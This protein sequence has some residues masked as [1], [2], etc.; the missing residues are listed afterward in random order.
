[1]T[2]VKNTA[3]NGD[4]EGS[5]QLANKEIVS[6]PLIEREATFAEMFTKPR[7]FNA[8]ALYVNGI[9]LTPMTIPIDSTSTLK[10]MMLNETK[11][12]IPQFISK[13]LFE[14][15]KQSVEDQTLHDCFSFMTA[16]LKERDIRRSF[17]Y[18][19]HV[20]LSGTTSG[21]FTIP[22]GA[23]AWMPIQFVNIYGA[24]LHWGL[25]TGDGRILHKYGVNAVYLLTDASQLAAVYGAAMAFCGSYQ[26]FCNKCLKST[27]T[28]LCKCMIAQYCSTK[29]QKD[30]W[31]FHKTRCLTD[32][33]RIQIMTKERETSILHLASL[34]KEKQ[35]IEANA[36]VKISA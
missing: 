13:A 33:K 23:R 32:A 28:R 8:H 35:I 21:H 2:E 7:I 9:R 17:E 14:F 10:G 20:D 30:D 1:M 15:W 3:S 22:K 29:C 5:L 6:F 19:T 26:Q 4:G 36:K 25:C 24:A 34:E 18:N 16:I 12:P 27:Q 11:T 31:K